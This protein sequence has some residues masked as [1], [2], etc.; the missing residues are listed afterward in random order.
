MNTNHLTP[1]IKRYALDTFILAGGLF[2]TIAG[3]LG[4]EVPWLLLN[5]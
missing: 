2:I 3:Y 5:I 4:H 1:D